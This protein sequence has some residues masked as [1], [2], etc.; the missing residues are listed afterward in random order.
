MPSN[1]YINPSGAAPA[2]PEWMQAFSA[3]QRM[4]QYNH[5]MDLEQQ[6]A[7]I[8][9]KQEE[10]RYN[11]YQKEEG[12][13]AAERGS[14]TA[15]FN[16]EEAMSG[17]RL[18]NKN[19]IP[20]QVRGKIGEAQQQEASG[21]IA[22]DTAPGKIEAENSKS[23]AQHLQQLSYSLSMMAQSDPQRANQAYQGVL[24]KY[25]KLAQM[26]FPPQYDPKFMQRFQRAAMNSPEHQRAT[27]LEAQKIEGQNEGH[28]IQG[29]FGLSREGLQ[30][31]GAMDRELVHSNDRQYAADRGLDGRGA[32]E[33]PQKAV[34]RLRYT[35]SR[36]PD[37]EQSMSEYRSHLEDGWQ[38][39]LQND[40]ALMVLRARAISTDNPEIQKAS[41][42]RYQQ[43]R[44]R[45][46]AENGIYM[47]APQKGEP[48]QFKD[49]SIRKFKGGYNRDPSKESSYE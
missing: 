30:Q 11:T 47:N 35:L 41:Q 9:R 1:N 49:G 26:G 40:P 24:Q 3:P 43:E 5:G 17:E 31:Q 16:V 4:Q 18:R 22:M 25:P 2:M 38:K 12:M 10:A 14:K 15:G 36:N 27:S 32:Q 34:A 7:E 37:D 48:R 20:S 23:G 28:R 44:A 33:T 39:Q 13:R 46:F 29:R 45:Y 19:Y 42:K 8:S 6:M 21:Q